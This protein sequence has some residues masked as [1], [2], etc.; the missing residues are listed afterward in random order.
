M[1]Q[2]CNALMKCGLS[3]FGFKGSRFTWTNCH[4]DGSFIKERLDRAIANAKW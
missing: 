2:F 3:D 1:L 4:Q